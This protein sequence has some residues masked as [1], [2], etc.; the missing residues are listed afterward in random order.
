[1]SVITKLPLSHLTTSLGD[2][3]CVGE[4][5]S[6]SI[7]NLLRADTVRFVIA[8]IGSP[9]HWLPESECFD[10]WKNEIRPHLAEPGQR[11]YLEQFPDEYAYFASQW[12]DRSSPIILLS[13]AH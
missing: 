5:G 4:I 2:A 6:E 9:L 8:D 10:R 13:K 7:R 11:V 3:R 1:M 12:D